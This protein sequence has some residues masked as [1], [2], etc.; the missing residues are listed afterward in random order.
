MDSKQV[1]LDNLLRTVSRQVA[2]GDYN[3]DI[4]HLAYDILS[5]DPHSWSNILNATTLMGENVSNIPPDEVFFIK[6]DKN[7]QPGVWAF[8]LDELSSYLDHSGQQKRNP[9]TLEPLDKTLIDSLYRRVEQKERESKYYET[10]SILD[11]EELRSTYDA[12][13]S[14][15]ENEDVNTDANENEDETID[16]NTVETAIVNED[17]CGIENNKKEV[18]SRNSSFN[19]SNKMTEFLIRVSHLGCYPDVNGFKELTWMEVIDFVNQ[20]IEE[21]PDLLTVISVEEKTQILSLTQ[22]YINNELSVEESDKKDV[23]R[24]L[25]NIVTRNDGNDPSRALIFT[26]QLAS[27]L[28]NDNDDNE[29]NNLIGT[30]IEEAILD[31][32]RRQPNE[33]EFLRGVRFIIERIVAMNTCSISHTNSDDASALSDDTANSVTSDTSDTSVTSSDMSDMSDEETG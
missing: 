29:T 17:C 5:Q 10:V 30:S 6:S 4:T 13:A 31:N 15:S 2:D 14:A 3:I 32:L 16:V 28:D 22:K 19:L 23:V 9:Y 25:I 24:F 12:N 27:F 7:Q 21:W 26:T 1:L 20:M 8:S 33:D 18:M 11:G